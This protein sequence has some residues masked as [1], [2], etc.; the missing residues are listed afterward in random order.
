MALLLKNIGNQYTHT[1]T[2][3]NTEKDAFLKA[4]ESLKK[5][6]RAEL[7]DTEYK[8][9]IIK[10]L[11]TDPETNEHV[12]QTMLADNTTFLIGRKGTGKS[13]I[14][15]RCQQ[16]IRES[17]D[18]ISIYLDV[19][20]LYGT[21]QTQ[22]SMPSDLGQNVDR[23]VINRYLLH[24]EFLKSVL[25]DI[26]KEF[27]ERI[28]TSILAKVKN[29]VLSS[30]LDSKISQLLQEVDT[31]HFDDMTL[32]KQVAKT[33]SQAQHD[34]LEGKVSLSTE[35]LSATVGH[36]TQSTQTKQFAQIYLRYFNIKQFLEDTEEILNAVG[37]K[38]LFI[39]FDDFSELDEEAMKI[40]VDVIL[41]PLNNWSKEFIK[42][43]VA[44]YPGRIYFG[45]I[46]PGKIDQIHL[47]F[48]DLYGISD[49][50]NTEEKAEEKARDYTRRILEKRIDY[51]S[52][53]QVSI[54][55]YFDPSNPMDYY[56]DLLFKMSMNVPRIMGYILFFAYP[57]SVAR[58]RLISRSVL[59]SCAERYYVDVLERSMEL[60]RFTQETFQEKIDFFQQIELIRKLVEK[61]KES[62]T[63]ILTS[64]A[65]IYSDIRTPPTS[66]FYVKKASEHY[67]LTLELNF[68]IHKYREMTDKEGTKSSVFALNYGLCFHENIFW[69]KPEGTKFRKYYMERIF[70]RNG[71]LRDQLLSAQ[72][73]KCSHCNAIFPSTDID[74]LSTYDMLCPKCKK[75]KCFVEHYGD[76][77]KDL[78]DSTPVQHLLPKTDLEILQL[79]EAAKDERLDSYAT[80]MSEEL[81]TS[82]QLIGARAKILAQKN[83]LT[84]EY[85]NLPDVGEKRCYYITDEAS[86]RYF[87]GKA[88]GAK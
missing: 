59:E 32:V 31:P 2:L 23:D 88:T 4:A 3:S 52:K 21:S 33:E 14:F 22:Y 36:N 6:R 86:G 68:F 66:H 78:L 44:A 35:P 74:K 82:Y 70:D 39:F 27:R 46:D 18:K 85:K 45:E 9:N 77:F 62:K 69:G 58:D 49:R 48:F 55:T 12:L 67:L 53:G 54:E 24:R 87:S 25:K 63:H 1:L 26:R 37:I 61:A 8:R 60:N 20:T 84:R 72:V 17:R 11:Y 19:K 57:I 81:D 65:Q 43:K 28:N 47:D 13:T 10:E 38:H 51:F 76:K 16:D 15:A 83:L 64:K 34:S 40:F 80:P 7:F 79:L 30:S 56:Y 75:G 29:R 50:S 73:I 71:M 42:L 5:Y 41:G